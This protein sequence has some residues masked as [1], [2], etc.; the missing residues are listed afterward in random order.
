VIAVRQ[1]IDVMGFGPWSRKE[2]VWHVAPPIGVL[3]AMRTLRVHLDDTH[4]P[5]RLL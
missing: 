3:A 2:G 1:R 5:M 4:P